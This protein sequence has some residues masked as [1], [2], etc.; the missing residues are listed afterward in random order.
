MIR[1]QKKINIEK[2]LWR[3]M[4]DGVPPLKETYD[5]AVAYLEGGATYYVQRH[6]KAA[7]KD[8]FIHVDYDQAGYFR[9]LDQGCYDA[10]NRIFAV[11]EEVK[12]GF[13]R[14]Y[15]EYRK[16]TDLFYNQINQ[17]E[18]RILARKP[19]GFADHYTGKR[20]L[21]VGRLTEQKAYEIALEA[22]S[23]LKKNGCKVRWYVL[24][25]GKQREK[26]QKQIHQLG[27]ENDFILLGAV[28]NPYP[29]YVQCD[30]YVHATRFEGKSIAVQEAQ[31]LGCAI[32]VSDTSG[33]REQVKD[34]YDGERCSLDAVSVSRAVE[35]L[36]KNDELR[37]IYGERAARI[38]PEMEDVEKLFGTAE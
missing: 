32:L 6:V 33:N 13:L 19:G 18:I 8:A 29:Y 28:K 17:N 7:Q 34:G 31:T 11:S 38:V 10:Y 27:L 30:L 37:K 21:T 4:A 9:G 3:V 12:D 5:L 14:V 20:I 24:G 1:V 23:L 2:L 22:M 36:L 35:R 25:E 26:L 15:P 16:K